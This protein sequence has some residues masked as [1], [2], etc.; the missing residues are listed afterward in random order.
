MLGRVGDR[1]RRERQQGNEVGS[2]LNWRDVLSPHC[3]HIRSTG[4][5]SG[6]KGLLERGRVAAGNGH[7][8]ITRLAV[9]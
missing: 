5:S 2:H 6:E 1:H 8:A 4:W 9:R 3:P 7:P